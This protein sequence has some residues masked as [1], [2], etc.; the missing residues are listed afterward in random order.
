MA[1]GVQYAALNGETQQSKLFRIMCRYRSVSDWHDSAVISCFDQCIPVKFHVYAHQ[2]NCLFIYEP[3]CLLFACANTTEPSTCAH[4]LAYSVYTSK[5][6]SAPV[7]PLSLA[8]CL[9]N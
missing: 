8:Q 4:C 2:L 5:R 1:Q 6:G 7:G 9:Y 3:V